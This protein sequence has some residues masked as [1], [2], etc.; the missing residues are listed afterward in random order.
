[1]NN[2]FNFAWKNGEILITN[3]F[4]DYAFLNKEEFSLFV[5][6]KVKPGTNLYELLST[7]GFITDKDV[8]VFINERAEE[9]RGMKRYLFSSTSLHIFAITN[10]CNQNCVY[11]QA[12]S[13]ESSLNGIMDTATG[14]KAI[15]VAMQSPSKYLTFEFQGGEPLLNFDLIVE[16]IAYSKELNKKYNKDLEYTIVTNLTALTEEKLQVLIDNNVTI[17]TSLDGCEAVH[18]HNRKYRTGG[19]TYQDVK[20]KIELIKSKGKEVGAIET[21][22]RFSLEYPTEI[23]DEYVKT[24]LHGI[25]IRPLTPLGFAKSYWNEVGYTASE[26]L[27]FYR[28]ALMHIIEINRG[29]TFFPE[30]H[31]S[32]FLRKILHGEAVNYM[33]LRSPC[34]A[35]IGQMSYYYNGNVYT[36]DEG[37]MLGEAGDNTFLLGNVYTDSYEDMVSKR[38]CSATCAA[39]VVETLPKC[40]DCVY[41]PYCG[42]CPV[43]VYSSSGSI[44]PRHPYDFRCNIYKGILDILFDLLQNEDAIAKNIL[45]SWVED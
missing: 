7:K 1:M 4:G 20:S 24:G 5:T 2:H 9:L 15:E 31:A 36:C 29:G 37:R 18:N 35:G 25:F 38:T 44:F 33:E 39:S 42:V 28:K 27:D 11:C 19:N 34:G 14:K 45:Y 8:D 30:L 3:D 32:Y 10:R 13:P 22:T 23:I 17:C 12:K 26:F 21:T 40:C 6:G 43:V 16:M 41:H